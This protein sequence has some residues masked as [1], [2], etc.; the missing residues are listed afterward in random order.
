MTQLK[1]QLIKAAV[2][3]L[4]LAP[5]ASAASILPT[6]VSQTDVGGGL[7]E[8]RYQLN[9]TISSQ[10]DS[11]LGPSY[12]TFYDI[13]GLINPAATGSWIFSTALLGLT[14]PLTAPTDNPGYLNVTFTY[15]SN[16]QV[17][18]PQLLT[19]VTFQSNSS[20]IDPFKQYTARDY[21]QSDGSPQS[22]I[23]FVNGPS[24][25]T[26][27]PEPEGFLLMGAGLIGVAYANRRRSNQASSP[28]TSSR[29]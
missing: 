13:P 14:A 28:N 29:Y 21:K 2:I 17:V 10:V 24:T 27:V 23:G 1:K 25:D 7:W 16:V 18:G 5:T 26:G 22:N 20:V 15:N 11:D 8:Y 4:L 9:L 19:T 3:V 12:F 6:Y